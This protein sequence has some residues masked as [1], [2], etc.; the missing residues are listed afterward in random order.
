MPVT[1]QSEDTWSNNAQNTTLRQFESFWQSGRIPAIQDFLPVREIPSEKAAARRRIQWVMELI[2]FDLDY[3]WRISEEQPDDTLLI[4]QHGDSRPLK[5]RVEDYLV[6]FPELGFEDE[7]LLNLVIAEYQTRVKCGD[8]PQ[9]DSYLPRFG[10]RLPQL[11]DRLRAAGREP[12]IRDSSPYGCETQSSMPID[13][14]E[15]THRESDQPALDQKQRAPQKLGRYRILKRIGHG[16]MGDVYLAYDTQLEREVALKT[17]RMSGL[18]S[19]IR[20]RFLREARAAAKLRHQNI[21][22]VY[23]VGEIDGQLFLTMHW[24]RGM[25]LLDRIRSDDL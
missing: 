25:N 21:C 7:H 23:D 17:P 13:S 2:L 5:L 8:A 18:S 24:V 15:V 11:G 19:E 4:M 1:G 16:A 20:H 3:R 22:P 9:P 6:T 14:A 10:D 12:G